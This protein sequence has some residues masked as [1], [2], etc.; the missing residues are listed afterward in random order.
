MTNDHVNQL[1][2]MQFDVLDSSCHN[3]ND[4]KLRLQAM[5]DNQFFSYPHQLKT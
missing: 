1:I 2:V 5:Q 3:P 4:N